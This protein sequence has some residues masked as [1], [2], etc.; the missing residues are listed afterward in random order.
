VVAL[1]KSI[2]LDALGMR[3]LGTD[4][5]GALAHFKKHAQLPESLPIWMQMMRL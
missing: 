4:S 3:M 1:T 5:P 2:H